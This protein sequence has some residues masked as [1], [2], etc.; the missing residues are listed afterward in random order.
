MKF[1]L[2]KRPHYAKVVVKT[3]THQVRTFK[4]V[5][6]YMFRAWGIFSLNKSLLS[7]ASFNRSDLLYE[8]IHR[9]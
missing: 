8:G 6:K 3:Q 7:M 9:Y 5:T 1:R 2:V 4:N